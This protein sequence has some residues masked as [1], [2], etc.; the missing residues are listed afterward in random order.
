VSI[1][2][3]ILTAVGARPGDMLEI[4][5]GVTPEGGDAIFISVYNPGCSICGEVEG[6]L[7]SLKEGR[8]CEDCIQVLS[9]EGEL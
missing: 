4:W 8:L 7:I 2:R 6:K 5:A 1:P 9:Q 3:E